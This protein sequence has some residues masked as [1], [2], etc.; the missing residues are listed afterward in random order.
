MSK[1]ED[2]LAKK[3]TVVPV[4]D[5]SKNIA[6]TKEE[7][8]R[9]MEKVPDYKMRPIKVRADEIKIK[10]KDFSFKISKKEVRK[11]LKHNGEREPIYTYADPIPSEM[12]DVTIMDLC[13]V[14]IDW[15]ML[16]TL[17]PKSK[18]EEEYFSRMTEMAKL[19]LKT[20][21]RDRREFILN[22]CIKKNKNKSG[23]VETKLATCAEC[24]QEMCC[25]KACMDF[26]YDLFVRI[27]PK[28]SKPKPPVNNIN[29]GKLSGRKSLTKNGMKNKAN[30]KKMPP[31]AM[32]MV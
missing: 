26:N 31:S 11:L 25:G 28:M 5:L 30:K 18:Q 20:E 2:I 12:K 8:K 17:R 24:G 29:K 14:P 15:K 21:M 16:T 23:I 4:L 3:K 7:F 6:Q 19:Q 32:P 9:L 13:S 1:L 10:E 22:N 27:E